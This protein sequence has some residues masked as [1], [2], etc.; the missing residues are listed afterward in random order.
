MSKKKSPPKTSPL[1]LSLP[2]CGVDSHAH[3]DSPQFAEDLEAV[4]A[5]ARASGVSRIGNVFLGP[6]EYL[7][8]RRLFHEHPEVFFLLG[9]HP[10]DGRR[11]TPDALEAMGAAFAHD[12][13]LRAVGEIGLDFYWEECPPNVQRAAFRA[14][15]RLA[16]ERELPVVIHCRNADGSTAATDA[17]LDILEKEHF[18]G[19]PL[20]WHCFGGDAALARRLVDNGWHVSIPG[21]VTYPANSALREA[22]RA[23]PADRI[24][25][26]TDCPYLAP[27]EWRGRRNEPAF[28]VF[29]AACV[30]RERGM[31]PAELWALC[32]DNARRF[33]GIEEEWAAVP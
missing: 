25:V 24:L 9:L 4:L 5:L 10:C 32:G 20:L 29:T 23:L 27:L 28:T 3:L 31:E 30:A 19:R 2:L 26:E 22:V 15:L 1:T 11:C 6:E 18:R 14:Q 33:F 17:V 12:G 16:R 8:N 13:R 21:P 7:N